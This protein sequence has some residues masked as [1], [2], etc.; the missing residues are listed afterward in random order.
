MSLVN[1]NVLSKNSRKT[2]STLTFDTFISWHFLILLL[3][4]LSRCN[5]FLILSLKISTFTFD[6][7]TFL[8]PLLLLLSSLLLSSGKQPGLQLSYFVFTLS[9]YFRCL[10]DFVFYCYLFG[11]CSFHSLWLGTTF[12]IFATLFS[13]FSK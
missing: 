6:T 12:S 7:F 5:Y 13:Y 9:L 3:S 8:A 4:L 11:I 2:T 10:C 1:L